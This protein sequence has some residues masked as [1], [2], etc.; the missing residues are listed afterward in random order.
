M[1]NVFYNTSETV[2]WDS[3]E[4]ASIENYLEEED[5]TSFE[6]ASLL[7]EDELSKDNFIDNNISE[8]NLDDY[9]LNNLDFD[10]L[11][12]EQTQ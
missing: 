10:D 5:F 9:L 3:I 1:F 4:I 2:T 6:L 8:D 7:T 11:I 12:I